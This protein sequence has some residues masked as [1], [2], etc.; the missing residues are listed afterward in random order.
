LSEIA[1]SRRRSL[2]ELSG[3]I[4]RYDMG[5]LLLIHVYDEINSCYQFMADC[6]AYGEFCG[7][8]ADRECPKF[9]SAFDRTD[10]SSLHS[11]S[12]RDFAE[13]FHG[14]FFP[15]LGIQS[16]VDDALLRGVSAGGSETVV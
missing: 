8:E 3:V 5:I 9:P 13:S 15:R 2:P 11:K 16:S 4:D 7:S 14:C 12:G 10:L 1:R 6:V